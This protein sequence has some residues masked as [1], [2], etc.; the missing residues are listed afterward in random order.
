MANPK[1]KNIS[2]H[3]ANCT[4]PGRQMKN[5]SFIVTDC[6]SLHHLMKL[7]SVFTFHEPDQNNR[8]YISRVSILEIYCKMWDDR[9]SDTRSDILVL[10]VFDNPRYIL[11]FRSS[12]RISSRS[13]TV[14][15]LSFSYS[16][17]TQ[18]LNIV[19]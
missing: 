15:Q 14:C 4:I 19:L 1:L 10:A 9:Y 13:T 11:I 5:I 18:T 12:S 16:N 2:K 8:L 17:I 3:P 7:T 6:G